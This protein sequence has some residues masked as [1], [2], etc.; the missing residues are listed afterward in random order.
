VLVRITPA[1]ARRRIVSPDWMP[2]RNACMGSSV[3][4]GGLS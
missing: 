2:S 3:R 4:K 1:S